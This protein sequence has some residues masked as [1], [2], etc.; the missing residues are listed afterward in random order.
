MAMV[1][2]TKEDGREGKEGLCSGGC[3]EMAR[4]RARLALIGGL[5]GFAG[6]QGG[7]LRAVAIVG[8]TLPDVW[9]SSVCLLSLRRR[10]RGMGLGLG[11]IATP[12]RGQ[13]AVLTSSRWG[14]RASMICGAGCGLAC[15]DVT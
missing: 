14:L 8:V 2:W 6:A 13:G 7:E 3:E 12:P 15:R 11:C 5:L 9:W 4:A 10:G 1:A